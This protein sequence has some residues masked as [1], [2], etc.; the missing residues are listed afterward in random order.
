MARGLEEVAPG[1][2]VATAGLW[3][4]TS[5][6]VVASDRSC[7]LVDP[8]LTP[9]ELDGLAAT[10]AGRGWRVTAVLSTHPHWDHLLVPASLTGVAHLASAAAVRA[11]REGRTAL[12]AEA[13]GSGTGSQAHLGVPDALPAGAAGDG[14]SVPTWPAVRL[15]EHRAHAPG[16]LTVVVPVARALLVGDMLSDREVPLL[17]LDAA[18][19]VTDY[20]A[21]LAL[22]ASLLPAADVVVPGHGTVATA[23]QARARLDADLRYLD[24]LAAGR[25][26]T[27]P[28]LGDPWVRAEHERQADR[29]RGD[30][31]PAA[32]PPPRDQGRDPGRP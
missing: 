16:H 1:V 20:V 2:H 17:D 11:A 23:A 15:A 25:P 27:D 21:G 12:V 22:L 9:A 7:L 32:G 29:L 19:P 18:D 24:G 14:P 6:V 3:A 26:G 13:A 31:G 5:T 4:T 30:P 8:A 28:R 10:V